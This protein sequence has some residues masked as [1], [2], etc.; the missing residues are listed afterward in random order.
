MEFLFRFDINYEQHF[1]SAVTS[2]ILN[3]QNKIK[4]IHII[5]DHASLKIRHKLDIIINKCQ[6]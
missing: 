3:N 2:L 4:I 6:L 5:L 1:G